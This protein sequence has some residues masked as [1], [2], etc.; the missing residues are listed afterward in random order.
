MKGA[1]RARLG[2]VFGADLRSL[3]LLR[4]ALA[5]IVLCDVG[6]RARD[7][8]VF[9][10][11][12]GVLPRAPYLQQVGEGWRWSLHLLSGASWVQAGLFAVTGLA[13]LA[14]L[15]GW[16]TRA[17]TIVTWVMLCSVQQRNPLL[18][19]G[20]DILLRVVLFW[21]MFLPLGARASLDRARAGE[22][23]GEREGEAVRVVSVATVALLLQLVLVYWMTALWKDSAA[24]RTEG[25]ALYWAL[26]IDQYVSGVGRW[27][28]GYPA[29]LT[30]LT[31]VVFW[32]EVVG[33]CLLLSP[34]RTG[35]VRTVAMVGFVA[36]HVGVWL[37]LDIGL[38]PFVSAFVMLGLL[39]SW[40][41]DEGAPRLGAALRGVERWLAARVRASRRA[42]AVGRLP[43]W[44]EVLCVA[45][46]VYV[47]WWNVAD[48]PGARVGLPQRLRFVAQVLRLEQRWD[49]F[50]PAP[51]R[52]DGWMVIAGRMA[53][54]REVDLMRGARA[55]SWQAPAQRGYVNQRWRRYLM[56]LVAPARRGYRGPYAQWLC[57]RWRAAGVE[58]LE[59]VFMRERTMPPGQ[60]PEV[61]RVPLWRERC[62]TAR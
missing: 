11:D 60:A 1:W 12:D 44:A 10:S 62:A 30:V 41:W 54:G 59:L 35:V 52:N 21:G 8:T 43:R 16:R 42:R 2:E 48:L 26:Q 37:C 24:W 28:R 18:E 23:A 57:R 31:L 49:M 36:L 58:S 9:Y 51:M 4:I 39:P 56:N 34:W 20:G 17:A 32:F 14:M 13:A 55:L 25:S 46:L 27:L 50:A 40:C 53:D 15:L 19:Q 7:L 33:P 38:F 47:V 5:G 6:L 3:A 22:S 61:T 45:C 29:A